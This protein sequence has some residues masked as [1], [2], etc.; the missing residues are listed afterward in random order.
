MQAQM[1]QC[2]IEFTPWCQYTQCNTS[3]SSLPQPEAGG[4]TEASTVISLL[5]DKQACNMLQPAQNKGVGILSRLTICVASYVV[6]WLNSRPHKLHLYLRDFLPYRVNSPKQYLF[7]GRKT[8]PS[9]RNVLIFPAPLEIMTLV[10]LSTWLE[11]ASMWLDRT[12][13]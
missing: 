11:F 13:H 9:D 4:L 8:L 2:V 6:N 1:Q 12:Q 7:P 5:V 10:I 3:S